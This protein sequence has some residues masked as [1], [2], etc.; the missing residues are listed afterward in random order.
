[1][2]Q[3][4]SFFKNVNHKHSYIPSS[5][6]LVKVQTSVVSFLVS[7]AVSVNTHEIQM[8]HWELGIFMSKFNS[9]NNIHDHTFSK[10]NNIRSKYFHIRF[11]LLKE[12]GKI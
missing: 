11:L 5:S 2:K 1:M 4:V 9:N 3:I 6:V 12:Q 10:V 8:F 7:L